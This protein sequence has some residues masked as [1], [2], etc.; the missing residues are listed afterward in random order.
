[1]IFL[2]VGVC[3]DFDNDECVEISYNA[4]ILISTVVYCYVTYLMLQHN[5]AE[6]DR[7]ANVLRWTRLECLCCATS[8][9]GSDVKQMTSQ[10]QNGTSAKKKVDESG[11]TMRTSDLEKQDAKNEQYLE[12][13]FGNAER[14]G[15][16]DRE[17]TVATGAVAVEENEP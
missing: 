6:Y 14:S 10:I 8:H 15:E 16:H 5:T 11:S 4:V 7:F 1:M 2:T 3:P 9:V 13:V 17:V 12:D